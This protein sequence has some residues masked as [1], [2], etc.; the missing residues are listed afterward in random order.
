MPMVRHDAVRKKCDLPA[1]DG[2]YQELL[3]SGVI[4][5]FVEKNRAFSRPIKDMEHNSWR[6]LTASSGHHR[7]AKAIAMPVQTERSVL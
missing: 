2:L 6:S 5:G 3:E 7:F 4:A 1:A